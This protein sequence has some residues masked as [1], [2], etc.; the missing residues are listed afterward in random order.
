MAV[1]PGECDRRARVLVV[2]DDEEVGRFLEE[3]ITASGY[4][5]VRA[6][7]GGEAVAALAAPEQEAPH[8]VLLDL[9]LPLESGVSVLSFLRNVMHSGLPVVVLTGSGGAEEE[10]AARSLGVSDYLLKPASRAQVLQAL[11]SALR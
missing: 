1:S 2:E 4:L 7:N 8:A 11:R 5:V 3:V 6:K 9:N 10:R